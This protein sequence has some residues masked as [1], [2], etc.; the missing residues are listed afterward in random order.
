MIPVSVGICAYN[1]EK[2]INNILNLFHNAKLKG[3]KIIEI[4]VVASGCT[5]RTVDIVKE[6]MKKDKRVKLI[7]EKRRR[8]KISALNKLLKKYRGHIFVSADADQWFRNETL[9]LILDRLKDNNVG[10]VSA[11]VVRLGNKSIIEKVVK[12]MDELYVERQKYSTSKNE[13]ENIGVLFALRRGLCDSIPKNVIN[14]DMYIAVQCK[15]KG[16]KAL[17]EKKAKTYVQSPKILRELINQKRRIIYGNLVIKKITGITTPELVISLK[18]RIL[19]ISRFFLR[20]RIEAIIYFLIG[21]SIELYANILAR[22]DMLK[23]YNPHI[24]WKIAKTTKKLDDIR[25]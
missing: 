12:I 4:L 16:Y 23:K 17:I 18:D 25:F 14:D 20:K 22:L 11:G 13:F 24:L 8:G 7:V 2:N 1:E 6:W 5:D 15:V 19:M 10:A 9:Q 21:Y 3:F